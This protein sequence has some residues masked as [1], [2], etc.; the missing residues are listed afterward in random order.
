MTAVAELLASAKLEAEGLYRTW[1]V[2]SIARLVSDGEIEV[3]TQDGMKVI[4]GTAEDYLRQIAR[5]DLLIDSSSDPTR[6]LRE[7][8]LSLGPQVPVAYGTAAPT[9]HEPPPLPAA[10]NPPGPLITYPAFSNLQTMAHR[11]L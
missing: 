3:H 10:A 7:V 1:R 11:G 8:N 4:F 2:V 9:L 6:P 5:L